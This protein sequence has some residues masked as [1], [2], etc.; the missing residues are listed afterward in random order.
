MHAE[1]QGKCQR[2]ATLAMSA[3]TEAALANSTTNARH[4][5]V[6]D[7]MLTTVG[8]PQRP[9]A[10]DVLVLN[11]IDK[12]YTHLISAWRRMVDTAPFSK[13]LFVVAMDAEAAAACVVAGL[14]HFAPLG[15]DDVLLEAT[16]CNGVD[17][18]RSR[19]KV[20]A[21]AQQQSTPGSY[22]RVK[23]APRE[24]AIRLTAVQCCMVVHVNITNVSCRA[25]LLLQSRARRPT[26]AS[27][28]LTFRLGRCMLCGAGW[29]S[30]GACSSARATSCG[31]HPR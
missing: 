18:W 10:G 12:H 11:T 21:V 20:P 27:Y 8:R 13:S 6:V 26:R 23:S 29:P 25:R 28:H 1:K 4:E 9:G 3:C 14:P 5:K 7:A 22:R 17:V 19:G 24:P 16:A 30:A 2:L 15:G 31:Y